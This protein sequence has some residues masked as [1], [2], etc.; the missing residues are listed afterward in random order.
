[1]K[2]A[3]LHTLGTTEDGTGYLKKAGSLNGEAITD[4]TKAI[5]Y[6]RLALDANA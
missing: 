1:L 6:I 5:V 4:L 3:A 2:T